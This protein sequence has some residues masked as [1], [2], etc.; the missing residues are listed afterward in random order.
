MASCIAD[1][2]AIDR[3]IEQRNVGALVR[4]VA[5]RAITARGKH[6]ASDPRIAGGL[7]DRARWTPQGAGDLS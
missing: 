1:I 6:G 4:D 2:I 5:A 7:H 3:A